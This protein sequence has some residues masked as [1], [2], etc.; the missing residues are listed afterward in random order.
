MGGRSQKT[1]LVNNSSLWFTLFI[2]VFVS[3]FYGIYNGEQEHQITYARWKY[4]TFSVHK[5]SIIKDSNFD[6]VRFSPSKLS[7]YAIG[8]II[9]IFF[10]WI[11]QTHA[12]SYISM[13]SLKTCKRG[14][15][16][17]DFDAILELWTVFFLHTTNYCCKIQL[18]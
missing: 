11:F 16:K 8:S 13:K 2:F 5:S 9:C 3:F 15:Q 12:A 7:G 1:F 17:L 14:K 6:L 18:L 10:K 4:R